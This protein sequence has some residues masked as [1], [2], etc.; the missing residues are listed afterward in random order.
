MKL[1]DLLNETPVKFDGKIEGFEDP[2]KGH[3]FYFVYFEDARYYFTG[4]TGRD[5]VTKLESFEYATKNDASKEE[6][7]IWVDIEGN[8]RKD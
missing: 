7:R 8:V 5:F 3:K 4:K 1:K 6:A 2:T